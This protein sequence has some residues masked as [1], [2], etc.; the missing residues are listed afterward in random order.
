MKTSAEAESMEQD[1]CMRQRRSIV[2]ER[3]S[4]MIERTVGR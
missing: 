1:V 4:L 3:L 2:M